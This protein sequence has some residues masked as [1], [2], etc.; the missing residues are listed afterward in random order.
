MN[1]EELNLVELNAQEVQEVEGGILS[2]ALSIIAITSATYYG[3]KEVGK[4]IYLLTH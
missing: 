3:S 2:L 1:L 4:A